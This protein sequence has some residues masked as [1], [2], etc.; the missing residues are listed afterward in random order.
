MSVRFLAFLLIFS[1]IAVL[2]ACGSDGNGK[3]ADTSGESVTSAAEITEEE[4]IFASLEYTNLDG[5][6]FRVVSRNVDHHLKDVYAEHETGDI[7][8]DAVFVRNMAVEELLNVDIEVIPLGNCDDAKVVNAVRMAVRSDSPDYDMALDHTH[9]VGLFSTEGMLCDWLSIDGINY[10]NPWWSK[11]V[12]EAASVNDRL[13]FMLSDYQLDGIDYT[14]TM[15]FNKKLFESRNMTMPYEMVDKGTWTMDNFYSLIKDTSEDLDGSGKLD[16]SDLWGLV[17]EYPNAASIV[18]FM[19]SCDQFVTKKNDDGIP[20]LCMNTPKM[21]SIAEKV[22]DIFWNGNQ[23]RI[24][25][26]P[27]SHQLFRNSQAYMAAC[28]V[29]DLVL[30]REMEDPYGIVIYPKYNE[31]QADYQSHVGGHA[32][33]MMIPITAYENL[34]TVGKIIDVLSALT[35]RDVTPKYYEMVLQTKALRDGESERM[36]DMLIANRVFDFAYFYN[37]GA[38]LATML[39]ALIINHSSNFASEYAKLEKGAIKRFDKVI[40]ELSSIG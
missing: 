20:E 3:G 12:I 2:P 5:Y 11:N 32:S 36:L 21:V 39:H 37:S 9:Q 31:E 8:N 4:D 18:S 10:D 6:K 26:P 25:N 29:R 15:L 40:E 27:N 19:Y 30:M 17:V 35:L 14:F 7:L 34:D 13:Y 24:Q 23:A 33:I 28:F 38:G 1:F 22:T 16:E